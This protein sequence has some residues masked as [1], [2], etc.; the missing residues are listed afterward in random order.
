M[1]VVVEKVDDKDFNRRMFRTMGTSRLGPFME[2][3]TTCNV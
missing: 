1:P 2:E 3:C